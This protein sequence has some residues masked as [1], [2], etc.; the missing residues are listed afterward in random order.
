MN[1][2]SKIHLAK[3][4]KERGNYTKS[5]IKSLI[6]NNKVLVNNTIQSLSY[7][8]KPN[9]VIT[10]NGKILEK[11]PMVYYLY[12]KP[13]GVICTNKKEIPDSIVNKLSFEHRV[14]CVGRLDKDTSGLIIL[15]N[16]GS[17][18]NNLMS[19]ISNIEKEYVVTV[20]HIITNEF[21]N[22]MQKPILLRGKETLP[23]IV[24]KIDDYT[25]NIIIKE[26]KYH[27][28]RRLVIYNKN[29]VI[30]LKRI[31]IGKYQLLDLKENEYIEFNKGD[32]YYEKN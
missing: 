17:F 22:N 31:R 11:V 14:F 12:H 25:F 21:I 19:P 1:T 13:V 6:L 18:S 2:L 8:I 27:Q 20:K 15:T 26:G 16:D 3:A 9:D 30:T 28:I 23:A 10:V 4:L 5:E 7:I 29:T 24:K 32:S